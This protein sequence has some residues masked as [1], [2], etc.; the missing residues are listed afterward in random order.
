MCPQQQEHQMQ[1]DLDQQLGAHDPLIEL[2][3]LSM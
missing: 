3:S 1:E 2:I